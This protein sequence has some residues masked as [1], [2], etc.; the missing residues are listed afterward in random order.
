MG[1][2]SID[3]CCSMGCTDVVRLLIFKGAHIFSRC[4]RLGRNFLGYAAARGHWD[5]IMKALFTIESHYQRD[6]FQYF[7]HYAIMRAI[8]CKS[9]SH[10]MRPYFSNLIRLCDDI[11]FTF[12]DDYTS[13][14]AEDNN[15]MHYVRSLEEA[16][17]LVHCGFRGFNQANSKG[18]LAINSFARCTN[19]ALIQFCLQ[20]GT[21]IN[22]K[23]GQNRTLL[24]DLLSKLGDF[25]GSTW[26]TIDSIKTCLAAGADPFVSDNCKCPCAPDGC[27]AV[28]LFDMRFHS[29]LFR[30]MPGP[31]WTFEWLS[32]IEEYYG[33]ESSRRMLLSFLR[34]VQSDKADITHVCC[35]RGRGITKIP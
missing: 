14:A 5:L 17:V 8:Y 20:K 35:H 2:L 24:F 13:S 1:N 33:Q 22:H 28:S 18:K 32:L 11:N 6:V 4:R 26:D 3:V 10:W 15:L 23:D 19:I 30:S 29:D 25:Y 31:V 27:L 34:R 16:E 12:H 7:V 21:D 9:A